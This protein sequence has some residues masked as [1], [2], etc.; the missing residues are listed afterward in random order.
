MPRQTSSPPPDRLAAVLGEV[1]RA[2]RGEGWTPAE[3]PDDRG[4]RRARRGGAAGDREPDQ[5]SGRRSGR[6]RDGA[7]RDELGERR[8]G[9]RHRRDP[10][11]DDD[12]LRPHTPLVRAPVSLRDAVVA[13]GRLAAVAVLVLVIAAGSVLGGRLLWMRATSEPRPAS[14]SMLPDASGSPGL[15]GT[16]RASA[17]AAAGVQPGGAPGVPGPGASGPGAAPGAAAP[18]AAGPGVAGPGAAGPGAA[19]TGAAAPATVFVHVVGQVA[20]PGV[21]TLR[22]GARV[23]DAVAAAGGARDGADLARVN[24]ARPVSDGEQVV[25]PKPGEEVTPAPGAPA[26]GGLPGSPGGAPGAGGAPPGGAAGNAPGAAG[27][28]TGPVNLNQADAAA[29]DTLP[30]IGP[31]LASRIVQWRTDNGRFT[32]VDEL[33]EVSG[34]GDKLLEQVRPQVTV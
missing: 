4:R 25:V 1:D 20:R 3:P 9:G 13:P 17:P 21:V 5:R 33:G 10:D 29:L 28:A 23:R 7:A 14:A 6:G 32:S 15:Q 30:G 22:P 31:V 18:G 27:P 34:I 11:A 8:R 19:S 26:P 12:V 2:R 16:P 24:L